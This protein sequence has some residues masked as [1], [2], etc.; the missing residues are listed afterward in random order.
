MAAARM[1]LVEVRILVV[2]SAMIIWLMS[3]VVRCKVIEDDTS[4]VSL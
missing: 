2:V 1:V 4:E 3:M